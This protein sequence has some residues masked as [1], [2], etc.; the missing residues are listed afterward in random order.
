MG[1]G[2]CHS[3]LIRRLGET[4]PLRTGGGKAPEAGRRHRHCWVRGR[5][6]GEG[7]C[8]PLRQRD[9]HRNRR[10]GGDRGRELRVPALLRAR[11]VGRGHPPPLSSPPLLPQWS[12]PAPADRPGIP[13]G[14]PAPHPPRSPLPPP[15]APAPPWETPAAS[16]ARRLACHR[17]APAAS[18]GKRGPRARRGLGWSRPGLARRGG[19]VGSEAKGEAAGGRGRAGAGPGPGLAWRAGRPA[20]RGAGPGHSPELGPVTGAEPAARP[21]AGRR[22]CPLG[23]RG[24]PLPPGVWRSVPRPGGLG[25][26]WRRLLAWR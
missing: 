18:G 21:G 9:R 22:G 7:G 1:Y 20:G 17:A 12:R 5:A 23:E 16:A 13:A 15:C 4:I 24:V 25:R 14:S 26:G 19:G 8:A 3:Q 10:A 2:I 6:A 11:P